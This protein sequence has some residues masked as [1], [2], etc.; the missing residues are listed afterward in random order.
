MAGLPVVTPEYFRILAIREL[1]KVG[2]EIGDLRIHRR[3]ELPE[4]ERGFVLE[5]A[6]RLSRSGS[7]W[8]SLVVCRRQSDTVGPEVI[9]SVQARLPEVPA[10]VALLFTTADFGA[11]A[12]AAAQQSGMALLRVVDGRGA[13]DMSGWSTPGHYPAWLPAYLAQL[14]DRDIAGQPRARLLEPDRAE[15]IIES[16]GRGVNHES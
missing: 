14:V 16:L 5:L 3:S 10:D 12:L 13:F 6:L 11:E 9:R 2:F 4:P 7:T 1:R 8:R 15:V